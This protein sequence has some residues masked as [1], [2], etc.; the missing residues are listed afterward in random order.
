[1][2][3]IFSIILTIIAVFITA[4]FILKKYNPSL[5]FLT[6]GFIILSVLVIWKGYTPMGGCYNRKQVFRCFCFCR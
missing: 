4:K 2:D 3:S 6:S 5:V 1:M